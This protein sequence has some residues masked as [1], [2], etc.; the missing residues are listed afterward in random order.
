VST[1]EATGWS[2]MEVCAHGKMP[3]S[4]LIEGSAYLWKSVV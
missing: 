4:Q 3:P 2:V 1:A